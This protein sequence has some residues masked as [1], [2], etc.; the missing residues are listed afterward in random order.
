M[1]PLDHRDFMYLSRSKTFFDSVPFQVSDK[2]HVRLPEIYGGDPLD[3]DLNFHTDD[4]RYAIA[5]SA[6]VGASD[7]SSELVSFGFLTAEGFALV[8]PRAASGCHA[9]F[10]AIAPE[11]EGAP[12]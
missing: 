10:E 1:D 2:I 5:L 11:F 3:C 7:T 8:R 4:S 6:F 12:Y 9:R